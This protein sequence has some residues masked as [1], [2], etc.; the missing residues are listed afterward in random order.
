MKITGID[1]VFEY[2]VGNRLHQEKEYSEV[3]NGKFGS[4]RENF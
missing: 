4:R 2:F 1:F 3:A